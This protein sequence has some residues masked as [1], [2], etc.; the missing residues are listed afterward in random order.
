MKTVFLT[1]SLI[2]IGMMQAQA[3]GLTEKVWQH[4]IEE[5]NKRS[6]DGIVSDYDQ[7]SILIVNGKTFKGQEQIRKVFQS[8]FHIFDNGE[9]KI[10]PVVINGR[11]V[12]ITWHFLPTG[13][14]R[15]YYGTDTFVI[16]NGKIKVQTI[17]SQLY[18][19]YPL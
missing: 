5:W 12:Y 14:P 15:E 16:E 13:A 17:A 18:D 4:H 3:S 1:L 9:N 2:F 6:L 10:D 8:L 19:V 11:I 7:S